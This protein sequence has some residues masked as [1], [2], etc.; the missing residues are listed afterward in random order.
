MTFGFNAHA[1]CG[2][3]YAEVRWMVKQ[4]AARLTLAY[5]SMRQKEPMCSCSPVR[6]ASRASG[7]LACKLDT[8]GGGDIV[9]DGDGTK[10]C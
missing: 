10:E 2:A 3:E 8:R 4:I 7:V 5:Y 1:R 6:S 9:L